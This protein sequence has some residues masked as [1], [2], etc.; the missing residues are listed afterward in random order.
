[1]KYQWFENTLNDLQ[2]DYEDYIGDV[3]QSDTQTVPVEEEPSTS[4]SIAMNMMICL[5]RMKKGAA[6]KN[7]KKINALIAKNELKQKMSGNP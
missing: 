3:A 4:V 6:M 7:W 5:I 2:E 1:M